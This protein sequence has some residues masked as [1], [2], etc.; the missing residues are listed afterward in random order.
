MKLYLGMLKETP[1]TIPVDVPKFNL[2]IVSN[3]V[4][5]YGIL[6]DSYKLQPHELV[7]SPL[8]GID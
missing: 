8:V 6:P 5:V 3:D 7:N 1:K 4:K 2:S